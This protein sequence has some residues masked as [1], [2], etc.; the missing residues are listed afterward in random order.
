MQIVCENYTINVADDS[1]VKEFASC[2][3]AVAHYV[4]TGFISV[5]ALGADKLMISSQKNSSIYAVEIF[6]RGFLD[7]IAIELSY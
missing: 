3:E 7:W 6:K 5:D 2:A 1:V 4:R